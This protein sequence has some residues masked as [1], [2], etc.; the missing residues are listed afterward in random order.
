MNGHGLD[1]TI[2][3]PK[4][5]EMAKKTLNA[6]LGIIGGISILGTTGIVVPFST[7]AWRASVLQS[8]GVAS[9]NGCK[10]DSKT[11]WRVTGTGLL[12]GLWCPFPRVGAVLSCV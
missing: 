1:V 2:S 10:S 12:A 6:R 7:A 9:A 5:E 8:I 4:G 3:V 11:G